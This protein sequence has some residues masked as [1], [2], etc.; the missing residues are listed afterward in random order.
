MRRLKRPLDDP[1][2]TRTGIA[3]KRKVM[4]LTVS[5]KRLINTVQQQY[6]RDGGVR[7][8]ERYVDGL[9][10]TVKDTH[11]LNI[12]VLT[13]MEQHVKESIELW[14][15]FNNAK[16]EN[17]NEDW[18]YPSNDFMELV[19]RNQTYVH[20]GIKCVLEGILIGIAG[21]VLGLQ[22]TKY[23]CEYLE[24]SNHVIEHN[25][26]H[27]HQDIKRV[28]N[29]IF[30]RITGT[31]GI[32]IS[33]YVCEYLEGL[34]HIMEQICILPDIEGKSYLL[35]DAR[36]ASMRYKLRHDIISCDANMAVQFSFKAF[37]IRTGSKSHFGIPQ[38]KLSKTYQNYIRLAIDD[39]N[40]GCPQTV[41]GLVS[42]YIHALIYDRYSIS[43]GLSPIWEELYDIDEMSLAGFEVE[44]D[45]MRTF[46]YEEAIKAENENPR[47]QDEDYDR[48]AEMAE[49]EDT[50][51]E[52]VKE[53]CAPKYLPEKYQNTVHAYFDDQSVFLDSD[54]KGFVGIKADKVITRL[55]RVLVNVE[56]IGMYNFK[57]PDH[58]YLP[59]FYIRSMIRLSSY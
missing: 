14:N 49:I 26:M 21:D 25:Y 37:F 15:E 41:F 47:Y 2:E 11:H 57:I 3:L 55:D 45:S 52:A 17:E 8:N 40:L 46:I 28:L 48:D 38:G 51:R 18:D 58:D 5:L 19:E 50:I 35:D 10:K 31:I 34:N 13:C 4:W 27:L 44:E 33:K 6:E 59:I 36:W 1:V 32:K 22:I 29:G 56:M 53:E 42:E 9:I 39:E 24:E 12:D 20:Y 54:G 16:E 7:R 23:V 30:T 43:M